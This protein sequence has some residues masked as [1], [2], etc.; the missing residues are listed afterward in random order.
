MT[1]RAEAAGDGRPGSRTIHLRD[2]ALFFSVVFRVMSD[3]V[4]GE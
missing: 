1:F 4:P 2:S 3:S